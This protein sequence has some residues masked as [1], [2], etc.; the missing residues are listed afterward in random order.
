MHQLE[1]LRMLLQERKKSYERLLSRY[2]DILLACRLEELNEL[3]G[4]VDVR[5]GKLKATQG[6]PEGGAKKT[7][8]KSRG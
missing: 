5:L 8:S 1:I 3:I 2:A 7:R 4:I 6:A